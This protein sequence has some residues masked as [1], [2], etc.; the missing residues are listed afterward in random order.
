MKRDIKKLLFFV[1]SSLLLILAAKPV[2]A[3]AAA[4]LFIAPISGNYKVG[5]LF[6]VLVNVNT[7]GQVINAAAGQINF[8]NARL[9]VSNVGYSRSIFTLW[10]DEPSYS[11]SAG[12][13]KFAGGLPNPGFIGSAGNIMRIT[14][15]AKATGQAPVVFLSGS[16][17]ANDGQGTNIIDGLKGALYSIAAGSS[18]KP[19]AAT[20]STPA[21]EVQKLANVPIITD[22]PK[23]LEA[24]QSLSI[25]G[26]G[27]P[28]SKILIFIQWDDK[29][30]VSE[31]RFTSA[32]GRFSFVY[33][34]TAEEGF[35]RIW[36][37]NVTPDG[38][39]SPS[40]EVVSIEVIRPLFFRIGTAALNYA[41]IIVT[42]IALLLLAVFLIGWLWVRIRKL[43]EQEG[44][45]IAAAEKA[46][47]H[48]FDHLREGFTNYI[49]YLFDTK[50]IKEVKQR[51]V[52]TRK[53]V[54]KELE[55]I[56]EGIEKEIEDI[57]KK[58]KRE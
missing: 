3:F 14:F 18:A 26:L 2:L 54:R 50:S 47:H 33:G 19:A 23:Q 17:L 48:S 27:Y 21:E 43:Q 16:V 35:Y 1:S 57:R 49:N 15:K 24:G 45:E 58:S 28:N 4:D 32:D 46:L 20:E 22:W 11:N 44:A 30:A 56:E 36:A 9:E 52:D 42:L 6:S 34:K 10:T 7:G 31:E 41:S 53:G 37:K 40:S 38:L 8:D 12:S 13:I 39:V 51:E 55:K 5:E 25:G 29:D